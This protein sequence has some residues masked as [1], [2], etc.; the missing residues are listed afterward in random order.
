MI[1]AMLGHE[2]AY[3]FELIIIFFWQKLCIMH[4]NDVRVK[5]TSKEKTTAVGSTF[6]III[7]IVDSCARAWC[8]S[9]A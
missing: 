4:W 3:V 7:I 6:D 9:N 2:I 5:K 1:V 8:V